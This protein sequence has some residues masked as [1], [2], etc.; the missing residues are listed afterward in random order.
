MTNQQ[1]IIVQCEVAARG[2]LPFLGEQQAS[3]ALDYIL[4]HNEWHLG[5]EFII[6]C[7]HEEENPISMEQF[8]EFRK[9]YEMM[10]IA[11]DGRLNLLRSLVTSNGAGE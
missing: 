4:R 8:S 2:V 11:D 5:L 7:L 10:E 3:E 1:E 6:D 9:A